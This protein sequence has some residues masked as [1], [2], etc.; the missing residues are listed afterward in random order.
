[1]P[2]IVILGGAVWLVIKEHRLWHQMHLVQ[3]LALT[4]TL[5]KL[6]LL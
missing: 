3:I 4:V 5:G 1:M 2:D 6:S